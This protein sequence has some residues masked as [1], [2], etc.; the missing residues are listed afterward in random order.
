MKFT[1]NIYLKT[2]ALV[3]ILFLMCLSSTQAQQ[4]VKFGFR[5]S[6]VIGRAYVNDST[7]QKPK[8]LTTK[9]QAS[10]SV[11]A[12]MMTEL[13]ITE[14]CDLATGISWQQLKFETTQP[15][16][17]GVID[18]SSKKEIKGLTTRHAVVIPLGLRFKSPELGNSGIRAWL[19]FGAQA[20]LN[21][22]YSSVE[23]V[24]V[25]ETDRAGNTTYSVREL[26][27]SR[28][29]FVETFTASAVPAMGFDIK[30]GNGILQP[31]VSG[32]LGLMNILNY[33][34]NP[35]NQSVRLSY[36]ALDLGYFF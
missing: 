31:A 4:G 6:P 27:T 13:Y 12:G 32:H 21:L 16:P 18:D 8:G 14:R 7:K 25:S 1:T 5:I 24:L 10:A 26:E 30:I 34:T 33:D 9:P 15:I 29:D 35:S 20:N 23:E 3:I 22:S 2:S 17:R 19:H 28:K 11:D 36:I